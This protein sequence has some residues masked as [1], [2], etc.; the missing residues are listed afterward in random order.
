MTDK[1]KMRDDK[2]ILLGMGDE[3][4]KHVAEVLG[5]KTCKKILDFLSERNEA[6]EKDISDG[7]GIPLNTTEYN[8]NKLKKSGLVVSSKN[9][10]WSRKGKKIPMYKLAKKHIII[11]PSKK[12]NLNALKAILPIL[13]IA[14]AAILIIAFLTFPIEPGNTEVTETKLKHFNSM[15]EL[16]TF[17]EENTESGS[18]FGSWGTNLVRATAD[19]AIEESMGSAKTISAPQTTGS[20]ASSEGGATD[21]STTNVQVEGVD[22][23]D[24]VKNDGKHIYVVSGNK[25]IIVDAYPPENMKVL[26]EINLTENPSQIFINDDKLIIFS[27]G[28]RH[29][30]Y[31]GGKYSN[32]VYVYDVSDRE[33]PTLDKEFEVEGN[34]VNSRMIGDYVY[35][36]SNKY[37]SV[38]NPEPPVYRIDEVETKIA[39]ED[40]YY[41]DYPD[42]NYVFTTIMSIN[43]E[44]G[45]YNSKVYLT[46]YSG[47]IYVSQN[48]IYLTRNKYLRYGSK[49][50]MMIEEVYSKVLP[51]SEFDKIQEIMNS[52]MKEYIKLREVGEV[53]EDYANSLEG[54]EQAEFSKQLMEELENFQIKISKEEEKT[55]VYKINI[56]K[57]QIN[58]EG[59]GE[60]PGRVLNQFSMDEYE[61]NF[62]IAT[63]TG[64]TW[65]DTS[66]NHLYVLDEDLTII[67][68]VEDLAKG[69][70]I[71]SARFLGD[72]AYLVTYKQVDPF[73]VVDLSNPESPEVLGYL[74]IPGYSSYL[75]PYDEN[76]IIGLG[77]E[78]N[79]L[80][81]SLFD[82]TNVEKPTEIGK[83]TVG[84]YYSSSNAL[85]DHKAFLFNKEKQLLVI[86]VNYNQRGELITNQYNYKYYEYKYWQGA[87]VFHIDLQGFDLIGK[88]N[89]SDNESEE[90]YYYGPTAVQRSLYMDDTLYTISQA[91]I[92]ANNLNTIQEINQVE[93]GYEYYHPRVYAVGGIAETTADTAVED[94]EIAEAVA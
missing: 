75:H 58:Y 45:D 41:W 79:K 2:Y 53:V 18:F 4:S 83:Y 9:F 68:S 12:P 63:T 37:I 43:T 6:S 3:R 42:T 39:A 34:Y 40:V 60:V 25:V 77:M 89:H 10:F 8:L 90:V 44:N 74:K 67:G 62:R 38:D 46:G 49:F 7:L 15:E 78:D 93:L 13:V 24:I 65:R 16:K 59:V 29:L 82:V 80:K 52:D 85:Y 26:S 84:G 14:I 22:E 5:N 1:N 28:Y 27:S 61:G 33:K 66:L 94:V 73:Y 57:N 23:A 64:N 69:E 81:L 20:L 17:V 35:V 71:Y 88:I 54:E 36:I 50:Q 86:P 70:R 51:T 32:I 19:F 56:N 30:K 91:K 87:F 21:Y 48:N 55:M 31:N 76:H 47:T 92:K 72:R 11:S